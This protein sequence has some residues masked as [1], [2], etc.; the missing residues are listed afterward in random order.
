[1]AGRQ[2]IARGPY[3]HLSADAP[4]ATSTRHGALDCHTCH[5]SPSEE[6][7]CLQPSISSSSN[8]LLFPSVAA[9]CMACGQ[10]ARMCGLIRAHDWDS[11]TSSCTFKNWEA[12]PLCES[13]AGALQTCYASDASYHACGDGQ[14]D[15]W[16]KVA[17]T[18]LQ[19]RGRGGRPELYDVNSFSDDTR[20]KHMLH[21][22][23]TM[24]QA[25]NSV[26]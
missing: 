2:H 11:T 24:M 23:I 6:C 26:K 13:C 7:S 14:K 15:R 5:A 25:S 19:L 16:D 8:V 3:A 17:R 21:N 18:I 10:H 22:C 20:V 9:T 4:V 12:Y 1:M